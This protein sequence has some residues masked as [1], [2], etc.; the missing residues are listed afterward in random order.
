[1]LNIEFSNPNEYDRRKFEDTLSSN[2]LNGKIKITAKD[3]NGTTAEL[4]VDKETVSKLGKDYILSHISMYYSKSLC[5]WF[6]KLS[7]NDYYND[8][9]RNPERVIRLEFDG[10]EEGTGREVYKCI[11]TGLYYLRETFYPREAFA[12]WYVCGKRRSADDGNEPRANLIF[13]CDG[14]REKVRYD[15]WNGVAAYNDT[16]NKNFLDGVQS[17][18]EG[19]QKAEENRCHV[20]E[21]EG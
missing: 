20:L 13:E 12:R 14:Q 2:C 3:E 11:E 1:M 6:L 8:P 5:S 18:Q 9:E 4:F 19:T 10:Y 7:Q 15:D 17:T 16:F 21:Q